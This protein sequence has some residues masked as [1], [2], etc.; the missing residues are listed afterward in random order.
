MIRLYLTSAERE[1]NRLAAIATFDAVEL[2]KKD[3]TY[4]VEGYVAINKSNR[5][6]AKWTDSV[7]GVVVVDAIKPLR[8]C[9]TQ[10]KLAFH[11]PF[12]SVVRRS[13]SVGP[14]VPFSRSTHQTSCTFALVALLVSAFRKAA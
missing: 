3:G 5:A 10:V 6:G 13:S 7:N 11:A 9:L 2:S 1:A 14:A 12:V 8:N 4:S